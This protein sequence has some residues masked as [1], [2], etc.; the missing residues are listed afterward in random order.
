MKNGPLNE[1]NG[2]RYRINK[3]SF[4]TA[5]TR[6]S[7]VFA[8]EWRFGSVC[9]EDPDLRLTLSNYYTVFNISDIMFSFHKLS[10]NA[11]NHKAASR[12]TISKTCY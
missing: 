2:Q 9:A 5:P 3:I 8:Y 4:A 1:C 10:Q 11:S 12:R 7:S 6:T